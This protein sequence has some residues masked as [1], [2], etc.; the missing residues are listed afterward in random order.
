MCTIW[1]W[2]CTSSGGGVTTALGRWVNEEP[3]RDANRYRAAAVEA[4]Q[5]PGS[6]GRRPLDES[7]E[8]LGRQHAAPVQKLSRAAKVTFGD[9]FPLSVRSKNERSFR[10]V[11]KEPPRVN[12][13][14]LE[15]EAIQEIAKFRK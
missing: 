4:A 1:G 13:I 8:F 3:I 5:R 10:G 15:A 11:L 12:L 6:R 14:A 2:T 7:V 9:R